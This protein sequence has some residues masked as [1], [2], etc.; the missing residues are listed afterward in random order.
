MT[1]GDGDAFHDDDREQCRG[2][3]ADFTVPQA[4]HLVFVVGNVGHL[5]SLP[6][7][8][9]DGYTDVGDLDLPRAGRSFHATLDV[10]GRHLQTMEPLISLPKNLCC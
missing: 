3:H 7:Y 8:Q 6:P 9:E 1:P 10:A 5:N 2:V 4:D